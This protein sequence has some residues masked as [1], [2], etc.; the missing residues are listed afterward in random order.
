MQGRLKSEYTFGNWNV[1][2]FGRVQKNTYFSQNDLNMSVVISVRVDD[3]D[4]V[5]KGADALSSLPE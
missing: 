5:I 1:I 4:N 3:D 2:R